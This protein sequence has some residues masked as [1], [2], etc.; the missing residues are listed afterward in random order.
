MAI[1]PWFIKDKDRKGKFYVYIL[2]CCNDKYYVGET[3]HLINR[4]YA[5]ISGGGAKFI[6]RHPP[7]ELVH[8]E[9]YNTYSEACF[10]EI[11]LRKMVNDGWLDFKLPDEYGELFYRIIAF[12]SPAD[13]LSSPIQVKQI[14]EDCRDFIDLPEF[15]ATRGMA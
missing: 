3:E 12:A 15:Q 14:E 9:F 13:P 7:C 11:L 4:L 10:I 6:K 8:L 1:P 5:H 2:R